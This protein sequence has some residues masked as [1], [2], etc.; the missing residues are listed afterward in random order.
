MTA[1][2]S[3][4]PVSG[5][6]QTAFINSQLP[7]PLVAQVLD[8][9]GNPLSGVTV[10]FVPRGQGAGVTFVGGVNTAV[11]NAQGIATSSAL[12]ANSVPGDFFIEAWV[13][14]PGPGAIGPAVFRLTT[15]QTGPISNAPAIQTAWTTAKAQLATVQ[16]DLAT[17]ANDLAALEASC[18]TL[19][20]L[21]AGDVV[22][23]LRLKAVQTRVGFQPRPSVGGNIAPQM[24]SVWAADP[25]KPRDLT[26]VDQ[27]PITSTQSG[28]NVQYPLT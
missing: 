26:S 2:A 8:A 27:R 9:N 6:P 10:T 1:A 5:A 24:L 3:I 14:T 13:G 11:T 16:A 18:D 25:T 4:I 12:R 28:S 21:G 23:W 17:L 20:S 22:D 15:G 19:Y 7:A